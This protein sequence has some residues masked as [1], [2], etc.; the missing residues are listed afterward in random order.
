MITSI[1]AHLTKQSVIVV[2]DLTITYETDI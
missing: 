2:C 1:G